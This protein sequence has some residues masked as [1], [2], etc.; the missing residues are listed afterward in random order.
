M[1]ELAFAHFC[2]RVQML[3][4]KNTKT[5]LIGNMDTQQANATI[6]EL[7]HTGLNARPGST[8]LRLAASWTAFTSHTRTT[9]E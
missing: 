4:G 2:E 6:R 7:S 8:G 5:L 9:R 3:V 1:A